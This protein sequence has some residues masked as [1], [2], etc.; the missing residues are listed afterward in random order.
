MLYDAYELYIVAGL[1]NAAHD[2]VVLELAP[3]AVIRRD[4]ELLKNLFNRMAGQSVDGWHVKGKVRGLSS[5]LCCADLFR[6]SW[7]MHTP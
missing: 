3:D 6:H 4:Y 1:W 7:T 5:S 2:L